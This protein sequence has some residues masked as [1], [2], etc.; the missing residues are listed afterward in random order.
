MSYVP[1]YLAFNNRQ[2]DGWPTGLSE[3]DK[4]WARNKALNLFIEHK[5]PL[6]LETLRRVLFQS[7][8]RPQAFKEPS[9]YDYQ[10]ATADRA[11]RA[12][13]ARQLWVLGEV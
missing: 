9:L 12:A 10:Y 13:G 4:A 3:E 8:D 2:F 6:D 11:M 5:R 1:S 7:E